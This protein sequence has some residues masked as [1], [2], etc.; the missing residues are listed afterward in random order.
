MTKQCTACHLEKPVAEFRREKKGKY[1]VE[2]RCLPCSRA[3]DKLQ[4]REH[5]KRR[6]P[7]QAVLA[8]RKHRLKKLFGMTVE[9]FEELKANQ[10]G[11]CAI[12]K[13]PETG[14]SGFKRS[15]RE[16]S[17]DHDHSTGEIR[18]LLCAACNAALG[19]FKDD[20]DV[21]RVAIAYLELNRGE[22]Q[23]LV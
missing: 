16:L 11:V 6:D 1:G 9:G 21:M 12:C 22:P 18:G 10:G 13:Q 4:M 14:C 5:R 20:T 7:K 3:I 23:N 8:M 17:V 2:S 19:L 15:K